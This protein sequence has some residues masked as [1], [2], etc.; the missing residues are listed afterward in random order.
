MAAYKLATCGAICQFRCKV[1]GQYE[2]IICEG[3]RRGVMVGPGLTDEVRCLQA[4]H[5]DDQLTASLDNR[6][7]CIIVQLQER[8]I[9]NPFDLRRTRVSNWKMRTLVNG[10]LVLHANGDYCMI[11]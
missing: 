7:L 1:N 5:G 9:L 6:T 10:A 2:S 3:S 4:S 11:P 8:R